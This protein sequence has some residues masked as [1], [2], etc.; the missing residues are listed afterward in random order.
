MSSSGRSSSPDSH[1]DG[2]AGGGGCPADERKR[3]R[4]LSNRESARRSRARKQQRLEELVAEVARLQAENAQVQA[5]IATFDREFSKV[6]GENAVLR[7]RATASSPVGW[8]RSPAC[9]RCSRWPA[10]LW[11]SRRSLTRCSAHGSRRSRCSP[12]PLTAPSSTELAALPT[13]DVATCDGHDHHL[14]VYY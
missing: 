4:M 2:S 11:T 1:T 13:Q 8:S 6:D 3:K 12:S 14:L 9:W 5:S 10:R 7:A